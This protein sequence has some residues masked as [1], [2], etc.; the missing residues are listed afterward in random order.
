MQKHFLLLI[1]CCALVQAGH[2]QN[3]LKAGTVA[4]SGS[5]NFTQNKED[6]N[7]PYYNGSNSYTYTDKIFNFN[8][9]ISYFVADNLAIGADATW[10]IE[11][12]SDKSNSNSST[13]YYRTTT[14]LRVGPFARRYYMLTDQF[15][16]TGTLGP[17]MS[18]ILSPLAIM[19]RRTR[20]RADFMRA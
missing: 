10:S 4:L 9:G 3:A 15:G 19:A 18:T 5:I 20:Q 12:I 16:F 17:A 1:I 11:E 7:S 2:A 8:P 6:T 14:S 13:P